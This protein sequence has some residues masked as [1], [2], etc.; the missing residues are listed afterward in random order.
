MKKHPYHNVKKLC[1]FPNDGVRH[2]HC[3]EFKESGSGVLPCH[4]KNIVVLGECRCPEPVRDLD[5]N[6]WTSQTVELFIR[7]A[8]F[9]SVIRKVHWLL[10]SHCDPGPER[11][12]IVALLDEVLSQSLALTKK[13]TKEVKSQ[14]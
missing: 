10:D 6:P 8:D 11:D 14:I 2:D 12:H 9:H 3:S 4:W 7:V 5:P 13:C 1:V